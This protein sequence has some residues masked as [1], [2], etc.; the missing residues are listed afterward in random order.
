MKLQT[1]LR[2][3]LYT[4]LVL[5]ILVN[6]IA[7]FHAYKF[8]H[9]KAG[10]KAHARDEMTLSTSEKLNALFFGVSLPRPENTRQPA[11]P[12][13]TINLQ[14]NKQIECWLIP[15][16]SPIGTVVICHGYGGSK[17]SM[18]DKA[19][20]LLQLHYNVLLPDFM[21]AGGSEGN[22]T[23]IGYKEAA[24]V[25]ACV[26]YL[27]TKGEQNIRLFGTSMGAA[28]IMKA[29]Q[30]DS[31]PVSGLILECPFGTMLRT[32][33]NRFK[34][35]D[36]PAFPMAQ[37]LV[38][39]GGII[40]GFNAFNHNPESY[41]RSIHCPVLLMHGVDDP[42]V[43]VEETNAIFRALAGPKKLLSLPN[44]GHSNYLS[45]NLQAWTTTVDSFLKK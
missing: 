40:N 7:I 24:E 18:L 8:T 1:L 36:A 3:A 44:T 37:L 5:F 43:S 19:E 4:L 9:F 38:F 20:V 6:A 11:R 25:K 28:A 26:D 45:N 12:F 42:K 32:V 41:A 23:T 39:W 30:D 14:S 17:A 22:V 2:K 10:I 27:S 21:G 16:D 29:M 15:A 33:Q 35:M 34:I 13:Q 31:L